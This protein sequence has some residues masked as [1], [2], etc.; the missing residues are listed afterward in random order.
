MFAPMQR[1]VLVLTLAWAC[2]KPSD[3][4]KPAPPPPVVVHDAPVAVVAPA[5]APAGLAW[6]L[7]GCKPAELPPRL[8]TQEQGTLGN[9]G[10]GHGIGTA[11]GLGNGMGYAPPPAGGGGGAPGGGGLR[12]APR[13]GIDARPPFSVGPINVNGSLPK[14]VVHRYLVRN[15]PKL[16]YCFEKTLVNHPNLEEGGVVSVQFVVL[17]TGIVEASRAAGLDNELD[18]CVASVLRQMELPKPEGGG[19]VQVQTKF[20]FGPP[21]R[22]TRGSISR[23]P[24]PVRISDV[25]A[26]TP[27]AAADT[28]APAD[29]AKKA[30]TAVQAAIQTQLEKCATKEPGSMRAIVK[31]DKS[32]AVTS[33]RAGGLGD[34]NDETCVETALSRLKVDAPAAEVACDFENVEPRP[35]R[36]SPAGG[37]TEL[38][39]T[40]SGVQKD[41]KPITALNGIDRAKT[42][43]L[44]VADPHVP[45]GS[46]VPALTLAGESAATIVAHRT[47]TRPPVWVGMTRDGR[48]YDGDGDGRRP[49]LDTRGGTLRICAAGKAVDSLAA[50]ADSCAKSPCA[51]LTIGLDKKDEL[52]P[53]EDAA[54]AAHAAGFDRLLLSF[55][56]SC[57]K[58]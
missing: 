22:S 35:W 3:S 46:L 49:V 11:N 7:V 38:D 24:P 18:D 5:D 41:G 21:E 56:A 34:H 50:L 51:T 2:N 6:K 20:T 26:W 8:A 28:L 13:D 9:I 39:V 1:W 10:I 44:V 33:V 14:E 42:A 19:V 37:Y 4:P 12:M 53:A 30:A 57:P 17:A 54:K 55:E 52:Q 32:G 29:A 40:D 47:D 58:L 25:T 36:V 43:F 23:E 15:I 48:A 45:A 16:K 31:L 27:Y